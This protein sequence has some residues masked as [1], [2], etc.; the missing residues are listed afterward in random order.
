MKSFFRLFICCFLSFLL[1][2]PVCADSF[3]DSCS[4][5]ESGS[6]R[7][8][9]NLSSASSHL[10]EVD[11]P[12]MEDTTALSVSDL[13]SPGEVIYAVQGVE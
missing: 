6:L 7:E 8:T 12:A 4:S 9:Y 13:T 10:A 11:F 2:F 5:D 3:T 1:S